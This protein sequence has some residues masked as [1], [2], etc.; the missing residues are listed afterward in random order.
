MRH[1]IN[2]KSINILYIGYKKNIVH[3]ERGV[4][5]LTVL[6]ILLL[7]SILVL[8]AFR[9]GF[10]NEILVGTESDHSRARAAAEA[11]LRDA[12]MDI[13]GRRPPYDSL[14]SNYYRGMPCRPK[15]DN[16]TSLVVE[17][18]Y[19]TFTDETESGGCRA[20][21]VANT[22]YIPE[23]LSAYDAVKAIVKNNQGASFAMFPCSQGICTPPQMTT[24]DNFHTSLTTGMKDQGTFYGQYTRQKT[25]DTAL[26]PAINPIL[27]P[28]TT[29]GTN[30]TAQAWYWIEIFPMPVDKD[31]ERVPSPGGSVDARDRYVPVKD[32]ELAYRITAIAIGR[33]Q[34]T[35]VVLKSLFIP[36]PKYQN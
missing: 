11:L 9:V 7:S 2:M 29:A 8:G 12:E 33:K 25:T 32:Q 15:P 5:L 17:D 18:N 20:R 19:R 13:R 10:L 14:Q 4:A 1:H 16:T 21:Q 30:S 28:P 36:F 26:D 23:S 24:L 3:S 22:P 6:I 27:Q 34:T 35:K 31:A